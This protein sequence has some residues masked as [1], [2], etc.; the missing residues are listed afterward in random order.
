MK[1][2]RLERIAGAL[3]QASDESEFIPFFAYRCIQS[4]YSIP[5]FVPHPPPSAAWSLH[6]GRGRGVVYSRETAGTPT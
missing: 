4:H 3:A 2:K 1:K 6:C 5:Y